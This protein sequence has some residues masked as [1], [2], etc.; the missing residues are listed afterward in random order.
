MGIAQDLRHSTGNCSAVLLRQVWCNS[1][2]WRLWTAKPTNPWKTYKSIWRIFAWICFAWRL[3]GLERESRIEHSRSKRFC[4]G[5]G[6][7]QFTAG[8]FWLTIFYHNVVRCRRLTGDAVNLYYHVG[9]P[10][11]QAEVTVPVSFSKSWTEN[12]GKS[13]AE[14]LTKKRVTKLYKKL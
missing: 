2:V 9:T 1:V 8:Y 11:G 5:R 14:A 7:T 10:P 13:S 12:V 3:G 4:S 6:R